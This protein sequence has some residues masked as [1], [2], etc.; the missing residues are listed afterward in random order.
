MCIVL[1]VI[2]EFRELFGHQHPWDSGQGMALVQRVKERTNDGRVLRELGA[3]VERLQYGVQKASVSSVGQT[4]R[5]SHR[6]C[7]CLFSQNTPKK[8]ALGGTQQK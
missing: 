6:L 1:R 4:D 2:V 8:I 3:R 5:S 7:A